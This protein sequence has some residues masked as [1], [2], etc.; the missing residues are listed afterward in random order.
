M[1][2]ESCA[3]YWRDSGRGGTHGVSECEMACCIRGHVGQHLCFGDV[4]LD[5]DLHC[6]S[7]TVLLAS[8]AI[9][10]DVGFLTPPASQA[11]TGY[12]AQN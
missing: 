9:Y 6:F 7:P 12:L 5:Y 10:E 11:A 3:G 4:I 2:A 8:Q 1:D